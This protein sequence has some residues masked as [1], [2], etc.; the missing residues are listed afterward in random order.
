MTANEFFRVTGLSGSSCGSSDPASS[1]GSSDPAPAC[2][3][4][5]PA[6]K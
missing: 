6:E 1:C 5:D 2:G 3:S 4:S